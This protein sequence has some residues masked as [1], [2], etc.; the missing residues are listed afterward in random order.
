MECWQMLENEWTLEILCKMKEGN[1]KRPHTVW[2]SLNEMSRRDKYIK[3]ESG[4]V[5]A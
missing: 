1:H 4:L 3:T 2:F 5:V